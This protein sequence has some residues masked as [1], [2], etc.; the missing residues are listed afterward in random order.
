[1]DIDG[2][3]DAWQARTLPVRTPGEI[4]RTPGELRAELRKLDRTVFWRD[5]RESL[6]ALV[7]LVG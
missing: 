7:L 4:E 5:V 1:M 3:K 6:V 2:L